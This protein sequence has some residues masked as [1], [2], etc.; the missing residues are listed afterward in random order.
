MPS[1]AMATIV[2]ATKSVDAGISF[3][4]EINGRWATG[5]DGVAILIAI[6]VGYC[7]LI[8]AHQVYR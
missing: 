4:A 8:P 5:W 6:A 3:A 1:I 2:I 7:L